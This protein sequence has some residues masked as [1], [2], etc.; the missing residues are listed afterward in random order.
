MSSPQESAGLAIVYFAVF[1]MFVMGSLFFDRT[2]PDKELYLVEIK[3]VY[4][5][6]SCSEDSEDSEDSC[7]DDSEEDTEDNIEEHNDNSE[8]Q[9]TEN[10]IHMFYETPEY[11]SPTYL[12]II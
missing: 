7:T 2:T 4:V 12:E 1:I 5:E 9:I 11:N 3:K 6:D 8:E 10:K